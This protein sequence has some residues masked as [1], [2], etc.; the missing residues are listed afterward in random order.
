LARTTGAEV[1]GIA[2]SPALV[3]EATARARA[4]GLDDL[5]RFQVADAED[6]PFAD[7]SFDAAMAIESL[8]HMTDRPQ[9]F[10]QVGRVLRSGGRLVLTDFYERVPFTGERLRMIEEYRRAALNSPFHRLE[11]YPPMLRDAG[12]HLTE[13]LD[14]S[15]NMDRHYPMLLERLREHR[16][17]LTA[18]YGAETVDAL[19]S[20]FTN[21]ARTG[22]PPCLL[23]TARRD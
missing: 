3:R 1:V 19:D 5:V 22:E 6:V 14:I 8:V 21:C 16:E 13:F 18:A 10:K 9:V 4:A 15:E 7:A 2:T 11:E 12:L 23:M 17:D 20:V